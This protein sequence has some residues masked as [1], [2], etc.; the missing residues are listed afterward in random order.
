MH[1]QAVAHARN[2]EQQSRDQ[3]DPVAPDEKASHRHETTNSSLPPHRSRHRH[4]R[5]TRQPHRRQMAST[6][7]HG[8]LAGKIAVITGTTSGQG[9][10]AALRFAAE[11]AIVHGCDIAGEGARETAEMVAAIGRTMTSTP[12][13]DLTDETTVQAWIDESAAPKDVSTFFTRMP[14]SRRSPPFATPPYDWS[15][16]DSPEIDV[17]FLLIKHACKYKIQSTNASVI[18]GDRLQE[19]RV[20]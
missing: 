17:V 7:T 18:L 2:I 9:R 6:L 13:V 12:S 15:R 3:S 1:S 16:R 20:R 19:F 8:R 14:V 5:R 10:E 11:Q 4:R